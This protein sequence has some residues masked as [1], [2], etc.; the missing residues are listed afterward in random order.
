[1]CKQGYAIER[2]VTEDFGEHCGQTNTVTML[3]QYVVVSRTTEMQMTMHSKMAVLCDDVE[4]DVTKAVNF[5]EESNTVAKPILR[6]CRE[7]M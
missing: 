6:S 4:Q 1:M 7:I 2:D 3:H 5:H